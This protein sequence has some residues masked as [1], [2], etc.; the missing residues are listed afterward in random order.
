MSDTPQTYSI[1]SHPHAM[2]Q[3]CRI[4]PI[5]SRSWAVGDVKTAWNY[6]QPWLNDMPMWAVVELLLG[7]G[8]AEGA[9]LTL[10][11]PE[12]AVRPADVFVI[13]APPKPKK[14]KRVRR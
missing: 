8:V 1:T 2:F 5:I 7:K 10:T 6:L 14:A 9:T 12:Q 4:E 13:D 11:R 3:I